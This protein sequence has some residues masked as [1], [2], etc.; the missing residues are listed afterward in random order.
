MD[1][2]RDRP[3]DPVELPWGDGT[4]AVDLPLRWRVLGQLHPQEM[5]ASAG[6]TAACQQ[7]LAAPLGAAPLSARDLGH[8]EVLIIT[9]DHS[10]P[11][12]VG[13]FLPAVL[14]QLAGAGVAGGQLQILLANGVHR[15]SSPKEVEAKLG[16][17]VAGRLAWRCHDAYADDL[18]QL[19][20]TTRGTPVWVNG[21]LPRADLIVCLGAIEPHLLLGFGGGLKMIVPG[22]AGAET[23][24]SNH[25]QGVDPDNFDFVG[26]AA[27][28][29]PMR[30]DLEEAAGMLGAEVFVVNAVMDRRGRPVRFFC[31]DPVAAHRAG[32]AFCRRLCRVEVPEQA[33]VVLAGS[34][35]LDADL[36]QSIKCIGNTLFA[37]RPSGVLLGCVY[38]EHGLGELPVPA[39]TL[40]Y[41]M[42]R[43]LVRLL[44]KR[45]I[46]PLV[47]RVKAGE[48]AEEVFVGN[49]GLQML[50]R[51]HLA[52]FSEK[53]PVDTGSKLGTFRTF[54]HLERAIRWTAGRV[55][56]D[57]TVWIFPHGGAT[58][59]DRTATS[60]PG[61]KS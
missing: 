12:P 37:C 45:R 41:G 1:E 4:L 23:I 3:H 16:R 36:R 33:D 14:Q 57:A 10:R 25:M 22:C 53:L 2:G 34:S 21:L 38:C 50:R 47:Q 29:S 59:V 5:E 9:D 27:E 30:L 55:R 35:P 56:K 13:E 60:Q 48:P 7:A 46:L 58:Y 26:A 54:D 31:G 51:N 28:D 8:K 61:T 52:L 40:P 20:T 17:V 24:A 42:L 44:G 15:E 18:V 32:V 11:T 43:A 39:R 6:V 19:G 49:F